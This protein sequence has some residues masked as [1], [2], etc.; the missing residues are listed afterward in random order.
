MIVSKLGAS[1][2]VQLPD[3]VVETLGL[4]EGDAVEVEVKRPKA[5]EP[6]KVSKIGPDEWLEQMQRFEGI[7]PPDFKF[8]RDEANE[9]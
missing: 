4:Q 2:V 6:P 9:R 3:D 1:L 8:N 7:L 5:D